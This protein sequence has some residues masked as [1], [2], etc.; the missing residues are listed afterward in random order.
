[1]ASPELPGCAITEIAV[2]R[3]RR[4]SSSASPAS[5][6][7]SGSNFTLAISACTG[8]M[9]AIWWPELTF[10]ICSSNFLTKLALFLLKWYNHDRSPWPGQ[11]AHAEGGA[12]FEACR[13]G[14]QRLCGLHPMFAGQCVRRKIQQVLQPALHPQLLPALAHMLTHLQAHSAALGRQA[15]RQKR[16][17]L[18]TL[19]L[20]LYT[21][22]RSGLHVWDP[23]GYLSGFERNMPD[24]AVLSQDAHQPRELGLK[25]L[26]VTVMDGHRC[27]LSKRRAP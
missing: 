10:R 2:S 15:Q 3:E 5:L 26:S 23:E 11:G 17:Q 4:S 25:I 21:S 14:V 19:S 8:D 9:H 24:G 22:T 7:N 20:T 6:S 18:Y 27:N 1:M 16:G 13:E 12:M